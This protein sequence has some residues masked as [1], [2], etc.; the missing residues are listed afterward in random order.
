M[1]LESIL[2]AG[3]D[4]NLFLQVFANLDERD[5]HQSLFGVAPLLWS[6]MI[7]WAGIRAGQA[8]GY[9]MRLLNA[10]VYDADRGMGGLRESKST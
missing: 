4:V 1:H 8:L 2:Q 6:I 9:A 3:P 5:H 10:A 7:A